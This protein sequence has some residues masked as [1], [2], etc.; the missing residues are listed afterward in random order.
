MA[1]TIPVASPPIR[2]LTGASACCLIKGVTLPLSS[3]SLLKSMVKISIR[4]TACNRDQVFV[5]VLAAWP[6]F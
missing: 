1:R 3:E 4:S 2:R 5:D 6:T